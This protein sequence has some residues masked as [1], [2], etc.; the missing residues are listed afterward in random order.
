M[1]PL[2]YDDLPKNSAECW[3]LLGPSNHPT[4][5]QAFIEHGAEKSDDDLAKF[6]K[7]VLKIS[8][9]AEIPR[10]FDAWGLDRQIAKTLQLIAKGR[11]R[12]QAVT[13]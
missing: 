4:A 5:I 3:E 2:H 6:K 12:G 9:V 8:G 10:L 11:T 7:T 1:E 13:R